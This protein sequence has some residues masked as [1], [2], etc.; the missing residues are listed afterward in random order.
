MLKLCIS[1]ACNYCGIKKYYCWYVWRKKYAASKQWMLVSRNIIVPMVALLQ[2]QRCR[3][4]VDGRNQFLAD[5]V[6]HL[7][8]DRHQGFAP[9]NLFLAV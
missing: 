9:F 7:L 2:K 5:T 4:L 6:F 8:L 1:P 3:F